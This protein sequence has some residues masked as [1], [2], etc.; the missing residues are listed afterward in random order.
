MGAGRGAKWAGPKGAGRTWEV[1]GT[2]RGR[3]G[4]G[5]ESIES[6]GPNGPLWGRRV[7]GGGYGAVWG[8]DPPMGQ[9]WSSYATETPQ[10]GCYGAGVGQGPP[11]GLLW[12]CC[13]A[14]TPL[15]VC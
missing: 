12:G 9:L 14:A 7:P 3:Y 1:E 5:I 15:W 6:L 8:S 2:P 11:M 13:G 10:W 4:A